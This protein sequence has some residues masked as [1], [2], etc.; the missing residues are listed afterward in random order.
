MSDDV[1]K[2]LVEAG[3]EQFTETFVFNEV[4]WQMLVE[5][6]NEDLKDLGVAKLA[7]RKKLL[8]AVALLNN[9][10][11]TSKPAEQHMAMPAPPDKHAEAEFRQLSVMFCDLVG[12]TELSRRLS[13]EQLRVALRRFQSVCT[14]TL[15]S[16]GGFVAQYMG[17]GVL[18]YFGYP[19]ADENDAERAVTAGLEVVEACRK[20]NSGAVRVGIATG[21]VIVGDLIGS[22]S[23]QQRAVTGETPNLAARLQS[24]A[25]SNS[26]V[27]SETTKRLAGGGFEFKD[28]G[29]RTIKGFESQESVWRAVGIKAIESRF[30][31]RYGAALNPLLGRNTELSLL[32]DRWQL[33]CGGEGQAVFISG[34]AGIGKSRLLEAL[35]NETGGTKP[36][37]IRYQCFSHCATSAFYP[38]IIHL[39]RAAAIDDNDATDIK[40]DKLEALLQKSNTR[41]PEDLMIF[42]HL[43]SIDCEHRY[44][45][46]TL[47][48]LQIKARTQEILI[49]QL[50][51]LAAREPVLFLVEDTHWID[52]ASE[53]LL[54]LVIGRIQQSQVL[55]VVTHRPV[56]RP[57]F[58]GYNNVSSLQLNRLGRAFC[59]G[60]VRAVAGDFVND[61][62][63]NRIVS[64]TDGIPLF[65]EELT[66]SL[67]E[68][69]LDIAEADIPATL[70]ASLLAR[71]DR[72]GWQAKEIIQISAVIGREIALDLLQS[73]LDKDP[74]YLQQGVEQ[75]VQ[76]ELLFRIGSS[77]R[78]QYSFKHALVQDSVYD[79]MLGEVRQ[80]HHLR[81]AT[82]LV[83][84]FPQTMQSAPELIAH[85]FT[86]ANALDDAVTYWHIAGQRSAGRS[87]DAESVAQLK[88]AVDILEYA[89]QTPARLKK[90]L[91]LHIDLTGPLIAIGGYSSAAMESNTQKAFLLSEATG[92]TDKIFPVL[93]S[94]FVYYLH[95]GPVERARVLA[96][97]FLE[98]A[99]RSADR[100]TIVQGHRLLGFALLIAGDPV[101]ADTHLQEIADYRSPQQGG[102]LPFVYGQDIE[103]AAL[104]LAAWA[105]LHCGFPQQASVL[106]D[107][108]VARARLLDH[109]N[110]L[111]VVLFHGANLFVSMRQQQ[112][113]RKCLSEL[114]S[115]NQ[116]HDLTVWRVAESI[117]R[118]GLL[119]LN[120]EHQ[121]VLA[122]TES[123]LDN[124][125]NVLKMKM[126]APFMLSLMAQANI[127]L[128]SF[129]EAI[130][131]TRRALD[132]SSETG[133]RLEDAEIL[134][135]QAKAIYRRSGQCAEAGKAYRCALDKA[136]TMGMTWYELRIATEFAQ[137]LDATG[138]SQAAMQILQPLVDS[139]SERLD[140]P[141]LLDARSVLSAVSS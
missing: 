48:P 54:E 114:S 43:L 78:I 102:S 56:W 14:E 34:E 64:R 91:S 73:V 77:S 27:V 85:H 111:G 118:P 19:M 18:V 35:R 70:R 62:V 136:R 66:K 71:I 96:A 55:L 87:A 140:L 25:Q 88:R 112:R 53:E 103:A 110:T 16:H 38:A 139:F 126:H 79:S 113:V 75:L 52:P 107:R 128:Q 60:L 120:G 24:I 47:S 99:T 31:S 82:T 141:D 9:D 58:H 76:A 22:G 33:A 80:V 109:A 10:D 20:S 39:Q 101:G 13:A 1:C 5:L 2:W 59:A 74:E 90:K 122:Q 36:V 137:Y 125:T 7:D 30:E 32:L 94:Q 12:S 124:Y 97:E 37:E 23:S 69:G 28:L 98:L 105:R 15:Q 21:L 116:K 4:D 51:T 134:R 117:V 72:L 61:E 50:L 41:H 42:A 26:V 17:D 63:V 121:Q 104:V 45:V 89:E 133:A 115:L 92:E 119:S 65:I 84:D 40:L 129:D 131:V 108:A 132:V 106:F 86:E 83:D 93:Y 46:Q 6:S 8:A 127:G 44:G 68:G 135:I 130:G 100:E 49:T 57:G 11:S 29:K 3:F 81:I 138:D 95:T 123:A 67:I